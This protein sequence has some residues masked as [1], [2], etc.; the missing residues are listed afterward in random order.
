VGRR[1]TRLRL[2]A[3]HGDLDRW[4]RAL[5]SSEATLA[6]SPSALYT[7]ELAT[8]PGGNGIAVNGGDT[9]PRPIWVYVVDPR[10]AN[11]ARAVFDGGTVVQLRTDLGDC[12]SEQRVRLRVQAAAL[13]GDRVSPGS[14]LRSARV[15][16]R[17]SRI[18]HRSRWSR[19]GSRFAAAGASPSR[20]HGAAAT[21]RA[22]GPYGQP[23][24][25]RV[26]GLVVAVV[27]CT[28][29]ATPAGAATTISGSLGG[30]KLPAKGVGVTS[31]RAVAADT[32]VVA[33][34]ARTASGRFVLKV[35]PGAY[36]LLATTTPFRGQAGVDRKVDAIRVATGTSRKLRLSLRRRGGHIARKRKPKARAAAGTSFV[37]VTYP[38]VWVQH[39]TVSGPE[40]A[41]VLRKGMADM[42]ITDLGGPIAKKCDGVL[43]ERE[44]LDVIIAEQKLSQSRYAD[45]SQRIPSGHLI[46]HN[47][48]VTGTLT[49]TGATATL[50]VT[51]TNTQTGVQRSVTHTGEVAG[52]G[53]FDLEKS[54]VDDVAKL[55]C[56]PPARYSGPVSGSIPAFAGGASGTFAWSGNITLVLDHVG[57]APSGSPEGEYAFFRPEGGTVHLT[58]DMVDGHCT[59]HGETDIGVDP[60]GGISSVQQ[61]VMQPTYTLYAAFAASPGIAFA[62]SGGTPEDP[63][64]DNG[65]LP[66]GAGLPV[67]ATKT[68]KSASTT[69][70]GSTTDTF[71][72]AMGSVHREWSLAPQG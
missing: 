28:V 9:E 23:M 26:V 5:W 16:V 8:T 3:R 7:L 63:C 10:K 4:G 52:D 35:K 1:P 54:V 30:G 67:L 47:R 12:V 55:I 25:V 29:A 65:T 14:V 32:G 70:A 17:R 22:H 43:V 15:S 42:L 24:S 18:L 62:W 31:V 61:G 53:I 34:D 57:P 20:R 6:V 64:S 36:L 27:V 41:S 49:I 46:G 50:T 66:F 40:E 59:G 11:V 48:T 68:L 33:A 45:P 60:S 58:L 13:N 56:D 19:C 39:F 37:S 51:V 44:H 69:L 21:G 38:A 2:P 71:P 72:G